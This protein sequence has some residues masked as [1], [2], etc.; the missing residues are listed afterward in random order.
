VFDLL[1]EY[2]PRMT[3]AVFQH[4]GSINR[5]LGD[6]FMAVFGAPE[7]LKDH[8]RAA[9]DAAFELQHRVRRAVARSDCRELR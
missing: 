8:A 2:F 1:N 7:H 9:I 3:E 4:R 5:F 6:G